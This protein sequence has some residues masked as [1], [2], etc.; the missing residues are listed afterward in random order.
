MHTMRIRS[1]KQGAEE[2]IEIFEI[3][4]HAQIRDD[5][6]TQYPGFS[7]I[8]L[9]QGNEIPEA[10]IDRDGKENDYHILLLTPKIKKKTR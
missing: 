7:D 6:Y 4:Q 3:E 2:E 5:A 8:V 10:I 9:W 1:V